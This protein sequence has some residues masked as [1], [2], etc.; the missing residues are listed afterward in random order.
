[1]PWPKEALELSVIVEY[2]LSTKPGPRD[3]NSYLSSY[4]GSPRWGM[5]NRTS[6]NHQIVDEIS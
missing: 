6:F 4:L 1:M 2:F 5:L 3:F